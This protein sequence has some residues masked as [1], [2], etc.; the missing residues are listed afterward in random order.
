MMLRFVVTRAPTVVGAAIDDAGLA[1]VADAPKAVIATLAGA[2]AT[3]KP[4]ST[5]QLPQA[6]LA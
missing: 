5:Q 6:K 2:T 4:S 1:P 3:R